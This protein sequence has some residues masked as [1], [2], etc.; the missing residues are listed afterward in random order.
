MSDDIIVIEGVGKKFG[1]LEA[2]KDVDLRIKRGEVV[3]IVGPSG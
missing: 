2:L 1:D 3:V